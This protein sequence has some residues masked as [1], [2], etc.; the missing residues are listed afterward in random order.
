M[1]SHWW[2]LSRYGLS[3]QSYGVAASKRQCSDMDDIY[4]LG[5]AE[6][7]KPILLICQ[8][9]LFLNNLNTAIPICRSHIYVDYKGR[10]GYTV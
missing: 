7:Q 5:Q 10:N 1:S 4:S 2:S 8:V 6:F 3:L 9:T